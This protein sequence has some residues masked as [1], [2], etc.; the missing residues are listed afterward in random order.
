MKFNKVEKMSLENE[1]NFAKSDLLK[2]SVPKNRFM[3]IVAHKINKNN[4]WEN[5]YF[6]SFNENDDDFVILDTF[7]RYENLQ[8]TVN[9]YI[10]LEVSNFDRLRKKYGYS[11]EEYRKFKN[12]D[13]ECF[14][15]MT[16]KDF[17]EIQKNQFYIKNGVKYDRFGKVLKDQN[18][19]ATN[20][21][22]VHKLKNGDFD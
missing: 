3:V 2:K 14:R 8:K 20:F 13:F 19:K 18:R 9:E 1:G 5:K 6:R 12:D 10:D 7:G 4:D 15:I 22:P 16:I 11:V 17:N 21:F